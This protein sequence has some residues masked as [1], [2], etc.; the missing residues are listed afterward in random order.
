MKYSVLCARAAAG[1][2]TSFV[3]MGGMASSS[4]L[5]LTSAGMADHF[6]LSTFVSGFGAGSIGPR[7]MAVASYG[8]VIVNA[9]NLSANYVFHDSDAQTL[10][11][12]VSHTP[13]S[14]YPPA[15]ATTKGSV[16]GSGGFSGPNAGQLIKFN[17]DGTLNTAYNLPGLYITNGMWTN[18]VNGHLIASG[19][20]IYDIDVSGATPTFRVIN[21]AGADGLTVSPD[22]KVVY[23]SEGFGYSIATGAQVFGPVTVGGADGIGVITSNN[24]LNGDLII[25]SNY[26]T[27][28]LIDKTTLAQTVI[29]DS[30][31]RGDY[32]ASDPNGTLL[33]TQSNEI[34][35]LSCGPG[36]SIG[37]GGSSTPEPAS[38]IL[39]G[40]GLTC[41]LLARR[42]RRA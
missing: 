21:S 33:V 31:S 22:G 25:N 28:T 9:S 41:V 14:A 23:T 37:G 20:N 4:P 35:R 24:S 39:L 10:A 29:A 8:N 7:G 27:L 18:P 30:G 16:Y 12:A 42:H 3:V 5:T 15:Y 13:V 11:S 26:G 40:G 34:M 2:L 36:C 17:N 6:S 1:L 32:V 19:S 38:V